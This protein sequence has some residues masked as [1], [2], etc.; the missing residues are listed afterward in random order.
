MAVLGYVWSLVPGDR[1]GALCT[2]VIPNKR[3]NMEKRRAAAQATCFSL[4]ELKHVAWA[5]AFSIESRMINANRP[6]RRA[7]I[8]RSKIDA[9]WAQ[10]KLIYL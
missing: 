8:L 5:T 3:T 9:L 7:S 4:R 10:L 1:S 6:P 2:C